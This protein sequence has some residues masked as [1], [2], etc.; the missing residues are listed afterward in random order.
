M[1]EE[2][3][4]K[5]KKIGKVSNIIVL[6]AKILVAIGIAGVVLATIVFAILPKDLCKIQVSGDAA[7]VVDLKGFGIN[8]TDEEKDE[9]I[10]ELSAEN[11]DLEINNVEYNGEYSAEV[12]DSSITMKASAEKYTIYLKDLWVLMVIALIYLVL[13]LVTLIFAGKLCKAFR[14][15]TSPFEEGVIKKLQVFAYSLIPWGVIGSF[16]DTLGRTMFTNSVE[17]T[18]S[19][20][21]G[22]VFVILII[23]CLTQVFKYGAM[24]QQESDET[25]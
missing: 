13:T 22:I 15:C 2:Y 7:V 18:I 8:F 10:K 24:L 5:V 16:V 14:D 3:I 21:L 6:I 20:D 1:K 19:I 23:L 4:G 25:L 9:I 12:D 11:M 17:A